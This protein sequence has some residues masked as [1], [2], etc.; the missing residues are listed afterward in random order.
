MDKQL[1][2]SLFESL[3]SGIRLDVF[4]L[5]VKH[6][7]AGLVAGEIAALLALPPTNLSFHLKAMT[8]AGLLNVTQEGRY[9][10]YRA[11]LK[12][13]QA[14]IDYLTAECCSGHTEH[15]FDAKPVK[16]CCDTN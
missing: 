16:T 4:R 12:V 3:A 1:A 8:H 7:P 10:R 9:Q 14:L 11:N 5:L 13:M 6:A 2:T 15:C